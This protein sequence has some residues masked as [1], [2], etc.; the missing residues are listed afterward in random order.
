[1]TTVVAEWA[2]GLAREV[3]EESGLDDRPRTCAR[4]L[5]VCYFGLRLCPRAGAEARLIGD[6]VIY[7][8]EAGEQAAQY[9]LA[10]ELGHE[11]AVD[12]GVAAEVEERVASRIGVALMLPRAPYLRDIA[13]TGWD[14]EAL[15]ELWPLASRWIHARR[16]AEVTRGDAVASRW[17]RA[18]CVSRIGASMSNGGVATPLERSLAQSVMRGGR[19]LRNPRMRAWPTADGAIVVCG[20]AELAAQYV[21]RQQ[22]A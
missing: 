14:I 4:V 8:A 7:P 1:M 22:I 15:G 9:F 10:H 5:A 17:T 13:N 12:A 21:R 6:R 3:S 20:A 18:G 16:L 19:A 11:T 2:E